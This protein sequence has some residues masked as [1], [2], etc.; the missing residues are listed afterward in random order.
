MKPTFE[1]DKEQHDSAIFSPTLDAGAPNTEPG[2]PPGTG[3]AAA[4]TRRSVTGAAHQASAPPQ[5]RGNGQLN[6][7]QP[8]NGV[9]SSG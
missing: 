2:G 8:A 1:F 5:R 4:R 7:A 3:A 9:R 6:A